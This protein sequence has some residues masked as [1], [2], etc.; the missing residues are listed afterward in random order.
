MEKQLS[1]KALLFVALFFSLLAV[2]CKSTIPPVKR[3]G[4]VIGIDKKNIARYKQLHAHVWPAVL[5]QISKA[6]IHNYSIYLGQTAPD[7]YYLFSY[8]E[9]TGRDFNR[10][11]AKMAADKTT[12]QWWKLTDPLQKPLPT[13]PKGQWWAT[14]REVF[15]YQGPPSNKKPTRHAS[16]IGID[17]KDILVY[18]QMHACV[19]PGVLATIE[20]CN[21][22]N[23]S[24]YLGQVEKGKYLLF[25]YFEYIGDNYDQ[26]MARMANEVTKKWWHYTDALQKPLPTRKPGQWWLPIDEIFHTD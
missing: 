18:T 13:R 15:H 6:H 4:Q 21:I 2:G 12:R 24:I 7:K 19:W 14:W 23:Y 8:F 11:M 17:Q 3:L 1:L 5:K 22:R 26:D 10:D 16:I 25:S 20:K 9:Y